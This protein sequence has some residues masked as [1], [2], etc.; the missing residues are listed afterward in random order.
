MATMILRQPHEY[1]RWSD[2]MRAHLMKEK[3]WMRVSNPDLTMPREFIPAI[4]MRPGDSRTTSTTLRGRTGSQP[5]ANG[6]V[7]VPPPAGEG[8]EAGDA[9]DAARGGG[10]DGDPP[11]DA[12]PP[13]RRVPGGMDEKTWKEEYILEQK[14]VGLILEHLSVSIRLA[15][16][17]PPEVSAFGLWERIQEHCK[18]K[19]DLIKGVVEQRWYTLRQRDGETGTDYASRLIANMED[20]L[21]H[22]IEMTD[23]QLK[24]RFVYGL[25]HERYPALSLQLIAAAADHS[26]TSSDVI[27]P[28]QVQER[29]KLLLR[30]ERPRRQVPAAV[31]P[32][33]LAMDARP[34]PREFRG[35]CFTCNKIGH[36]QVDCPMQPR[37]GGGPRQQP[38][39]RPGGGRGGPYPGRGGRPGV[40]PW[41][42][43]WQRWRW[44]SW[45]TQL[46]VVQLVQALG[47]PRH[48][49]LLPSQGTGERGHQA[50]H[51]GPGGSA[52]G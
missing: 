45:S 34:H 28:V 22:S 13:T 18:G 1:G 12:A 24:Q 51:D 9:G 26:K 20:L 10:N 30:P 47:H 16:H 2:W 49:E 8:Q 36:R 32:A 25:D 5:D 48:G 14:C 33:M 42:G 40:G 38:S 27:A 17:L 39:P 46:Q 52:R 6:S 37:G 7:N 4:V 19:D 31:A 23:A 3:V 44:R 29:A 35:R 15:M 50:Q 11:G 41:A 43:C 21:V